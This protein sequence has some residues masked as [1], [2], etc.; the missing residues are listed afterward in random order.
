ILSTSCYLSTRDAYKLAVT[1]DRS[2]IHQLQIIIRID[3][4]ISSARLQIP[5]SLPDSA[6]LHL[7]QD[8]ELHQPRLFFF[9]RPNFARQIAT[10]HTGRS[11][12]MSDS[13][14][15]PASTSTLFA[16]GIA[17]R[18]QADQQSHSDFSPLRE[19]NGAIYKWTQQLLLHTQQKNQQIN[20][21]L[22]KNS[23]GTL[24]DSTIN[25]SSHKLA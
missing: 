8:V 12:I 17:T 1:I 14:R 4:Q 23:V 9:T 2:K 21:L 6:H 25:T 5:F 19:Y 18:D 10:F 22:G 3:I 13:T 20:Q 16:P 11:E 7:R 24:D 15:T